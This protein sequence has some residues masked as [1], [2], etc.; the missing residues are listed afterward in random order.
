LLLVVYGQMVSDDVVQ[1]QRSA[2][3]RQKY[4]ISELKV[5]HPDVVEFHEIVPRQCGEVQLSPERPSTTSTVEA[6]LVDVV[7]CFSEVILQQFH[8][9]NRRLVDIAPRKL[10][11]EV[12]CRF[13]T[14]TE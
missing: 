10:E 13:E 3:R 1:R 12:V 8:D 4:V 2:A 6:C 9:G 14:P 7:R 5:P 11:E